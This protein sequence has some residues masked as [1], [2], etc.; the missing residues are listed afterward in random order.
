MAKPAKHLSRLEQEVMN[1]AWDLG[2]FSSADLIA[3]FTQKRKLADTTIRT[4]LANLRKKG[5]VELVPSVGRG[6]RFRPAVAREETAIRSLK[7]LVANLFTGSPKAAISYLLKEESM[8][9]EDIAEI[10]RTLDE[11]KAKKR[12]NQKGTG[13]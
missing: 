4:V 7:E 1:A 3:A 12:P 8:D 5:Y 2:C 13:R 6:Y 9:E 11:V 10:R